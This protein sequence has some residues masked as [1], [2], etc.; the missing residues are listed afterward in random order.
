MF[1]PPKRFIKR[2]PKSLRSEDA[3]SPTAIVVSI[4]IALGLIVGAVILVFVGIAAM[5]KEARD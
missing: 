3:M 2:S 4:V 5:A 1:N